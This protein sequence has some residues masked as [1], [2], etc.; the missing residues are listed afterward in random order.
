MLSIAASL[1][2]AGGLIEAALRSEPAPLQLPEIVHIRGPI[3]AGGQFERLEPPATDEL[4]KKARVANPADARIVLELVEEYADPE[5]N[6][7]LLGNARRHVALYWASIYSDR[8]Q[9]QVL[10]VHDHL[11]RVGQ[12]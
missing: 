9:R 2:L 12:P 11:H 10:V 4:L 1:I 3:T 8:Q 5:R 7:P 6:Y